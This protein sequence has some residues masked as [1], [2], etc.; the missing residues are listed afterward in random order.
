M[1]VCRQSQYI[2]H[3]NVNTAFHLSGAGKA[4][5]A[6]TCAFTCV[7]RQVM[8]CGSEMD[9]QQRAIQFNHL[10]TTKLFNVV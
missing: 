3:T 10:T 2:N 1:I 7:E 8:L 6:S 5:K 9:F 4:G